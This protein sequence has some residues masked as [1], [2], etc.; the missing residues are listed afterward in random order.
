VHASVDDIEGASEHNPLRHGM[1]LVGN[2]LT[3]IATEH[4]VLVLGVPGFVFAFLG[5]GFGY[6]TVSTFVNS[7]TFPLGLAVTSG[8]FTLIGVFSGFTAIILHALAQYP[9]SSNGAK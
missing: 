9:G 7:G 2:L 8:F 5:V 1:T 6:G 4:P 3:T